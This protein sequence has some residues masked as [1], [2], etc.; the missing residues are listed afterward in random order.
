MGNLSLPGSSGRVVGVFGS[1]K[2]KEGKQLLL[3]LHNKE[4]YQ[5]SPWTSSEADWSPRARAPGSS[6]GGSRQLWAAPTGS[7]ALQGS[8]A[9]VGSFKSKKN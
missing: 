5:K 3:I 1:F 4:C 9:K 8:P 2:S 7:V 6:G